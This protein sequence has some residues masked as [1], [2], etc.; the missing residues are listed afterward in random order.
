MEVLEWGVKEPSDLMSLEFFPPLWPGQ[1]RAVTQM[2]AHNVLGMMVWTV[3]RRQRRV[4]VAPD[5]NVG[6]DCG[7]EVGRSRSCHCQVSTRVLNW[8]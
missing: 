7:S 2:N 5:Q 1:T 4:G 6:F 3:A 8:M